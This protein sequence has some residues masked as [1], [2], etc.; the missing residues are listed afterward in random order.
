MGYIGFYF[1]VGYITW[2]IC[3]LMRINELDSMTTN[4]YLT[5]FFMTMLLPFV[6]I[7]DTYKTM[8]GHN[9]G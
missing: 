4:E 7:Y 3:V 1:I 9:D 2:F 8:K 6:T 5:K